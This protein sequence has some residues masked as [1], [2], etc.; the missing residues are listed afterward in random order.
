MSMRNETPDPLALSERSESNGI[1]ALIDE[2]ARRLVA[3]EPSSSLRSSVRDRIG[4]RRPVWLAVPAWGAVAAVVIAVLIVG[5][6]FVGPS[7]GPDKVRPTGPDRV[8]PTRDAPAVASQSHEP[9]AIQPAP[10][11][12]RQV[13]R[14]L[15]TDVAVPPEE[16]S[17]IPPI[18]IDPLATVPLR[19]VP[20]EEAQ[21]AVDVSSGVMPIDIAP[22]QI[23]PLLGQ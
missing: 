4:R 22:L 15:A 6:A 7:A 5:R 10:S 11:T 21:I 18:A 1:D 19:A 23:E 14:R 17:P 9:A 3:G 20:L 13:A 16:E 8:S 2:A 12:P